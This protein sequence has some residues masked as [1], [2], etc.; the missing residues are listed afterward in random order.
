[1]RFARMCIVLVSIALF[2]LFI[3]LSLSNY[4][5]SEEVFMIEED[6]FISL[7]DG[8]AIL[9][10]KNVE[11]KGVVIKRF[12]IEGLGSVKAVELGSSI[13]LHGN[14]IWLDRRTGEVGLNVGGEGY[15]ILDLS[16]VVHKMVENKTYTLL[17]YTE[18]HS[19]FRVQLKALKKPLPINPFQTE[20]IT[21]TLKV[22]E[23]CK[24]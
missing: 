16:N 2:A 1:M 21:I 14:G 6:S 9:H 4:V 15:V 19:V 20:I 18:N 7:V 24:C 22:S 13:G 23:K 8:K 11:Q 3:G 5:H 10:L 17:I 12:E